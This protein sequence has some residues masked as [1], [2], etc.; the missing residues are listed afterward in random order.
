MVNKLN[1]LIN[2]KYG[3]KHG[4]LVVLELNTMIR[5]APNFLHIKH[6]NQQCYDNLHLNCIT[7]L[8]TLPNA[9]LSV[10][11][12]TSNELTIA[13]KISMKSLKKIRATRA[14]SKLSYERPSKLL[15]L[16]KTTLIQNIGFV[17]ILATTKETIET[18]T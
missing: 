8:P 3:N 9:L 14:D 17:Q 5:N 10:L 6:Y 15:T 4:K 12:K 1:E 7:E 2:C 13:I 18:V 16:E 11:M